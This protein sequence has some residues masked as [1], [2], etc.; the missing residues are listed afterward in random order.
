MDRA[1]FDVAR[2]E[3][4]SSGPPSSD[5]N[6]LG[7][8]I[9]FTAYLGDPA[10]ANNDPG[11]W[12][13]MA[14]SRAERPEWLIKGHARGRRQDADAIG[15]KLT[16]IWL[17]KLRYNFREAHTVERSSDEV[18]LLGVTQIGPGELWVTANVRIRLDA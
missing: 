9:D 15:S 7:M 8:E 13:D 6:L 11:L 1:S 3:I 14:I 5:D 18:A 10:Y 4:C 17:D 2:R 12:Q 16:R